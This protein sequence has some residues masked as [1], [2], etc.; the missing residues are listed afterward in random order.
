MFNIYDMVWFNTSFSNHTA[1]SSVNRKSILVDKCTGG[2][3]GTV[4]FYN[5]TS[6]FDGF[7][8]LQH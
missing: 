1:N 4:Y 2:G 6:V 8:P 3:G 5:S 7:S